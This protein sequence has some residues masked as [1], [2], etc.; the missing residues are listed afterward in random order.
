MHK[1]MAVKVLQGRGNLIA[2][3]KE[4]R[5]GHRLRLTRMCPQKLQ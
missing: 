5:M 3:C 1:E 2:H 4:H